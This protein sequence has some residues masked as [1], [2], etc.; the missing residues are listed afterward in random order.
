MAPSGIEVDGTDWSAAQQKG[1]RE[2]YGVIGF[3]TI[4]FIT[5]DGTVV[6]GSVDALSVEALVAAMQGVQ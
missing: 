2:A 6:T 1:M 5:S 4:A 3:P